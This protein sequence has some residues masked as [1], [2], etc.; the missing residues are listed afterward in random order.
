MATPNVKSP[1]S[2]GS[3]GSA[4]KRKRTAEATDS[5][6]HVS[7]LLADGEQTKKS[8]VKPSLKK[9]KTDKS[10]ELAVEKARGLP[11]GATSP[12]TN[13]N[14]V[15]KKSPNAEKRKGKSKPLHVST[16]HLWFICRTGTAVVCWSFNRLVS[17]V[18]HIK[19]ALYY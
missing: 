15:G 19:V 12:K 8:K 1:K 14:G 9:S 11:D 3:P 7:D 10:W 2:K 4:K 13:E 18:L 16:F 6:L 5:T 17:S